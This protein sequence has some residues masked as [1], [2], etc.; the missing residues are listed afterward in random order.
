M[1][2]SQAGARELSIA[3]GVMIDKR[4]ILKGEPTQRVSHEVKANL[5]QIG[6]AI[7]KELA[8]RG[9]AMPQ[10]KPMIEVEPQ[11]VSGDT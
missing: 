7:Y 2:L 9:I 1:A 4:Q 8:R 3:L 5:G 6:E 11:E 10:P